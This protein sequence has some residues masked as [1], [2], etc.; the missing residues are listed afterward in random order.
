MPVSWR[1]VASREVLPDGL[2]GT[3]ERWGI[4]EFYDPMPG[5]GRPRW[6]KGTVD[7][8]GETLPEL[9]ED[10]GRMID[11]ATSREFLDLSADPPRL[12]ARKA[13]DSAEA[14]LRALFLAAAL[15]DDE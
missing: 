7:P 8:H 5:Q 3:E 4:R 9:L 11:G 1:Y 15:E 14:R 2:G 13:L 12:Q 10:L 6:T